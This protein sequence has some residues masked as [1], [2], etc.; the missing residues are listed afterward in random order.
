[1]PT[2]PIGTI[3]VR[4]LSPEVKEVLAL[5]SSYLDE[6]V[7]YGSN[8]LAEI[9]DRDNLGGDEEAPLIMT[10][11]NSLE[12]ID[13]VSI[14]FSKSSIDPCKP[15]LRTILESLFTVC[16]ITE[17]N[18]VDRALDYLVCHHHKKLAIYKK[19]DTNTQ[20]GK[21]WK[22]E[23]QSDRLMGKMKTPIVK[24]L[25][26]YVENIENI[27]KKPVY[28]TSVTEYKRIKKKKSKPIWHEFFKGPKNK[29]DLAKHL[30]LLGLYNRIL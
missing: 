7:N 3:V 24:N 19:L 2:K 9:G 16:Y 26:K 17:K 21:Q 4:E 22:A 30:N 20:Q 10:L 28:K 29:Y 12:L 6:V 14:L 11:R 8:I 23:I 27:L 18:S 5:W 1:M 25:P 15:L 13:A